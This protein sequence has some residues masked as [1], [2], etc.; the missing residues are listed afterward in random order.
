[1]QQLTSTPN[2]SPIV[3]RFEF[4]SR[5]QKEGESIAVFVA[6]LRKIAEH[7][8]F[9][10]VLSDMLRDRLVCGTRVKTI[11]RRFLVEPALTFEKAL[12]TALAAE[13]ADKDSKRL[14]G[15][16]LNG[17]TELETA[18][19]KVT[20]PQS[21][22]GTRTKSKRQL[23]PPAIVSE[24]YR[25]G[26]AHSPTTC[27][28]KEF[29]CYFCKKKGHL[30]KKCRQKAKSKKEQAK[31]VT[32]SD[33]SGSGEYSALF[34]VTSG[35]NE[36]YRATVNVNGK[37]LL[38]K[39]DTGASVSVVGEGMFN[40][41]KEGK[42]TVELEK[43]STRL[44]TYTKEAIPVVGSVLVPVEHNGQSLT[45]PLIVT[46]GNGT[47]LLGRDWLSALKLDWR[48]IFSVGSA[49]SLQQVL[50]K[51]CEVFREGLGELRGVE[52]KIYIDK[53]E[54]PRYYP[55]RQVP[56][57]I[58][59]KVEEELERLQALGV[60]WPVQFSDWAAPV[61]PVMKSDG[62]IRL[63]GDYKITVNRAAK[64]EKYPIP[65][66]EELFAS[67]A[68]GKSFTK[69]DHAYLQIRLDE[70]SCHFVTINT[71]KGLFEYKRLT[72]GV[73]SAPSI[74]QRT[75]ENLLQGIKGIWVYVDDILITSPTEEEHL[76]NL[77]QVLQRLESAGMRLKRQKCL[78]VCLV[79]GSCHQPGRSTH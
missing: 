25:C 16:T 42:S 35:R 71:H 11:Q 2:P 70:E 50:D 30:P 7:C 24:C 57:A 10:P 45:L 36:P 34:Q 26:G 9:V 66:I 20:K 23:S 61:V 47:P 62:R 28:C 53:D 75:M 31:L 3:K 1:M 5:C 51:H 6:E 22:N 21:D 49:L 77:A 18:V 63:C 41:I 68:A 46:T 8:E 64:L 73:A 79:P 12:D 15:D 37:H 59:E 60:I 72:F 65:R 29:Q 40:I 55:A 52:A 67:L 58:R 69:L 4:N 39:I 27:Y 14:T 54:R 74:F 56:F 19:N 32:E 78:G 33:T 44:Q 43:T 48:S 76:Q 13:A 17:A 38:M